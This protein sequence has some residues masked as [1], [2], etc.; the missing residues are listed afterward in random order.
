ML[1]EVVEHGEDCLAAVDED[2]VVDDQ[3]CQHAE[4]VD[5]GGY[6][7]CQLEDVLDAQVQQLAVGLLRLGCRLSQDVCVVET[8]I[9]DHYAGI[10]C[11][12]RL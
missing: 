8:Q 10:L 7:L 5:M 1:I 9:R 4:G 3:H 6:A 2:V 12:R 11:I